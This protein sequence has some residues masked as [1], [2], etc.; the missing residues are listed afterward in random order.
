MQSPLDC[1]LIKQLKKTKHL[2]KELKMENTIEENKIAALAKHL[3]V[4]AEE[5][6][7]SDYRDNAYG[8]DGEDYLV[9]TDEEADE[10]VKESIKES[11][12]A[13]NAEFIISHTVGE[14]Y[15]AQGAIQKMQE[16]LCEDANDVILALIGGED[17]LQE[18]AEDAV[19]ADGRGH[20]L[21]SYDGEEYEKGE[22]YIYQQ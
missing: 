14:P 6:Q 22:F 18:F 7:K 16:Q 12:W 21:N 17:H 9:V 4:E 11:L 13:F 15:Q 8:V 19:S 2:K 1:G 10:A 5:I 20:F 3:E